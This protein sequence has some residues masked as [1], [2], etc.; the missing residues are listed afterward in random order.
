MAYKAIGVGPI[1]PAGH[2]IPLGTPLRRKATAIQSLRASSIRHRRH[3]NIVASSPHTPPLS[4]GVSMPLTLSRSTR[5]RKSKAIIFTTPTIRGNIRFP[6]SAF[7]TVPDTL[8][9]E[10]EGFATHH[11][12]G[13]RAALST[14]TPAERAAKAQ[15]QADRAMARARRFAQLAAEAAATTSTETATV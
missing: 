1:M 2:A 6:P 10:G 3:A 8:T 4:K 9:L 13:A 14:L 5:T 7:D 15:Q 12:K 11:A